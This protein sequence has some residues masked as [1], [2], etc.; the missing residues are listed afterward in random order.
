MVK[1]RLE[2]ITKQHEDLLLAK[3]NLHEVID[4][5]ERK[6]K[7]QFLYNFN[8]INEKFSEVFSYYLMEEKLV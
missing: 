3:E 7:K 5:M 1:E 8:I 6:M 2:F 4:D